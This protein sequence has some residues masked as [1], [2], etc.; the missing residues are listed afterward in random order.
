MRVLN[1]VASHGLEYNQGN[2][3]LFKR[4]GTDAMRRL[5]SALKLRSFEVRFNPGGIA[6]AGDLY[7]QGMFNDGIGIYISI[8]KDIFRSSYRFLYRTCS[9]LEDYSG[10]SNNYFIDVKSEKEVVDAIHRLCKI[11]PAK[12][13]PLNRFS[14][15]NINPAGKKALQFTGNKRKDFQERY[16]KAYEVFK[17]HLAE[18]N[19]FRIDGGSHDRIHDLTIAALVFDNL[20]N[21]KGTVE[22]TKMFNT[23][24][25]FPSGNEGTISSLIGCY[26]H[27]MFETFA[28]AV[29]SELFTEN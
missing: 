10:G 5:A 22:E 18:G 23:K 17:S 6:V 16:D 26:R 12:L 8:S 28:E 19:Y 13:K 2:K 29:N 27:E 11:N 24:L 7:L 14:Q 4:M 15:R 1:F 25:I 21:I 20:V 3:D 9:S